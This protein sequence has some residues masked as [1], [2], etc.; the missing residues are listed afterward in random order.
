MAQEK[1]KKASRINDAK[2]EQIRQR[3]KR[4]GVTLVDVR[5][6]TVTQYW[7]KAEADQALV[8][9]GFTLTRK[10]ASTSV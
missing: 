6:G 3:P 2:I 7:T 5:R 10:Q 4:Q 8:H 9:A 1:A